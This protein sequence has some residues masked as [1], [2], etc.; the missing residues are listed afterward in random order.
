[1]DTRFWTIRSRSVG[2]LRTMAAVGITLSVSLLSA[3]SGRNSDWT[4][5]SSVASEKLV[6][7]GCTI[8]A[9]SRDTSSKLSSRMFSPSSDAERSW[10]NGWAEVFVI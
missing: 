6:S 3:A 2:S 4:R 8:P 9:S 5:P 10:S 1:M 7:R